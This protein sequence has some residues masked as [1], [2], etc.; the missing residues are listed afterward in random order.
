MEGVL[1]YCDAP[2]ICPSELPRSD[3]DGSFMTKLVSLPADC[4]DLP[5][6]LYGPEAGDDA[7]TDDMTT[8]QTRRNRKGGSRMIAAPMRPCRN[9]VMI[10][11][12]AED[13][14]MTLFTAYGTQA[15]KASPKEPTDRSL[16]DEARS[17]SV[18]FWSQHA[19]ATGGAA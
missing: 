12:Q 7:I 1:S 9:L 10:G 17:E 6:A 16:T 2:L 8:T 18:R 5:S 19:L 3:W 11:R 13:G 14:T 4:P 15:N